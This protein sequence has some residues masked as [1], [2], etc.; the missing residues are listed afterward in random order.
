VENELRMSLAG[1]LQELRSRLLKCVIAVAVLSVLSLVFA[2]ELFGVLMK[3]VLDALPPEGRRLIYTSGI[4]EINV[5]MKVGLYCGIFLTTPVILWQLWSFV[6]PGLYAKERKLAAPF[7]LLG[8]LAFVAGAL[9]C[10]YLMLPGMFH[11]LLNDTKAAEISTRLEKA[12]LAEE[13]ALR[14]LRLGEVAKAGEMARLASGELSGRGEG[15]VEEAT[16][17]SRSPVEVRARL[18]GLGR[19]VDAVQQGPGNR[20]VLRQVLE[21]RLTAVNAF[22][23]GDYAQASQSMDDAV[24]LLAG[25]A[26]LQAVQLADMWKLEKQLALGKTL[27]DTVNWTRPMLTM[28]EQLSLVLVLELAFGVIF[29]LPLVMALLGLVG[30]IR[31]KTLMKYQRHAFVVCLIVAAVVTPTGDPVNLTIMTAPMVLCY[32]L[33]VL[34]VWII[35]KRRAKEAASTALTSPTS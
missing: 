19:L 31:A 35:E 32:E 7:V 23:K 15:Q 14:F 29:E 9:F 33:G 16:A 11:F 2:K 20:A 8:S 28:R 30:L 12:Q 34:A 24:A 3:P 26:T 18:E 6:S 4:E 22:A 27:R 5:L 13:E 25:A 1:H 10:Y 21:Q 17:F